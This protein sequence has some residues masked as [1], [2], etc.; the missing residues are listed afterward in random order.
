YCRCSSAQV[1]RVNRNIMGDR[2]VTESNDVGAL[3]EPMG[4]SDLPEVKLFG[5]WSLDE[6][7]VSDISLVDYVAV[8]NKS[9]KYLPHS[10]GRYQVKRFRKATCPIVERLA[11]S[12]MMHGRNNGK[13]LMT[14]RIVKHA[15][16]IIHLLSGEN[17]VQVLVNAVINS[18][19]REDS[20]RIGR[21]GTVRRQAVDVSPLR[22]VNQAIW[23]LCTGAREAAFRNIKTI[24]ECLADELINAAKGSSNSYAIKKKDELERVAKSNR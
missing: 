5:K 6:V 7:Y 24:A 1:W 23:L 16:E 15:F 8:K 22:R 20:T 13:K 11:S 18:G 21:A 2:W 12:M 17:P 9:A 14:V 19:P 4:Q 3:D 10:A